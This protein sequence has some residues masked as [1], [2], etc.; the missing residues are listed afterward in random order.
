MKAQKTCAL[1]SHPRCECFPAMRRMSSPHVFHEHVQAAAVG[2]KRHLGGQR[3][4]DTIP[5]NLAA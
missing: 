5:I 1:D 2:R 4:H 3:G